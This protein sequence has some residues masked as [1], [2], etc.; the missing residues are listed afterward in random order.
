MLISILLFCEF[1]GDCILGL[2]KMLLNTSLDLIMQ[3]NTPSEVCPVG[4]RSTAV[5][6]KNIHQT[7][8][9]NSKGNPDK[10]RLESVVCGDV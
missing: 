3:R 4:M 1:N 7:N 2:R 10:S 6:M 5:I 8:S 9:N